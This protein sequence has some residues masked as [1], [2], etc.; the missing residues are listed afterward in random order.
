MHIDRAACSAGLVA[1]EGAVFQRNGAGLTPNTAGA[2]G[3]YEGRFD[4]EARRGCIEAAPRVALDAAA[5]YSYFGVFKI[6][7]SIAAADGEA[8]D[9]RAFDVCAI[10]HVG[11]FNVLR[12]LAAERAHVPR[13][14][15]GGALLSAREAA[16]EPDVRGQ[17]EVVSCLLCIC[18]RPVVAA[19]H[20][21]LIAVFVG[22]VECVGVR[23]HLAVYLP[24]PV[25]EVRA[26]QRRT[27]GRAV[28]ALAVRAALLLDVQH[29]R[30]LHGEG[31]AEVVSAVLRAVLDEE[32]VAA[33][34]RLR[35]V[36]ERHG[37]DELF[38]RALRH[39]ARLVE[40]Q[41]ARLDRVGEV[42]D[43][44]AG[45]CRPRALDG[46]VF[47]HVAADDVV[48]AARLDG[49]AAL[50]D[51]E[52]V[53]L[54]DKLRHVVGGELITLFRVLLP[55]ELIREMAR[56]LVFADD[57]VRLQRQIV[58]G[59][60]VGI[61]AEEAREEAPELREERI[62]LSRARGDG[63]VHLDEAH[64]VER[65]ALRLRVYAEIAR[66]RAADVGARVDIRARRHVHARRVDRLR[67]RV[68]VRGELLVGR[69]QAKR[70]VDRDALLRVGG[71][72]DHAGAVTVRVGR[73]RHALF[74]H[75]A[76]RGK[77]RHRQGAAGGE[78]AE[79][80]RKRRFALGD[81]G[82]DAVR[83]CGYIGACASPHRRAARVRIAD[84]R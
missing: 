36:R 45:D 82:S 70:V 62:A 9:D 74:R 16:V 76:V 24:Q 38:A 55:T 66:H 7:A 64:L 31:E 8:V 20:P 78:A 84:A 60:L 33:F 2:V 57:E 50:D 41:H 67:G 29:L 4:L 80:R 49:V 15:V 1:G 5:A 35:V 27:P 83:D 6:D 72:G 69:E 54:P 39:R 30:R 46:D 73:V 56:K 21:E 42:I 32:V 18:R 47:R 79:C 25:G 22:G 3:G 77:H 53:D 10:K 14:A 44:I 68:D 65:I 61:T 59:V 23:N 81:A 40:E 71:D 34:A 75:V 63:V 37:H 52:G 17:R 26:C 11:R 51:D 12:Q 43:D 48:E 28:A 58:L 19:R 13:R